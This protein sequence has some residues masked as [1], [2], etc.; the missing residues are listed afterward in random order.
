MAQFGGMPG[1]ALAAGGRVLTRPRAGLSHCAHVCDGDRRLCGAPE[2]QDHGARPAPPAGTLQRGAERG[3][4]V[5]WRFERWSPSSRVSCTPTH[6]RLRAPSGPRPHHRGGVPDPSSLSAGVAKL[7]GPVVSSR[8]KPDHSS[9][10][11]AGHHR[12]G[13]LP[14]GDDSDEGSGTKATTSSDRRQTA[15]P[16]PTPRCRA[17][18]GGPALDLRRPPNAAA[19]APQPRTTELRHPANPS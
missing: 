14:S 3:P 4:A 10:D 11:A 6:R 1:V 2:G 8:T 18:A 5:G 9:C 19:S 17:P 13:L 12:T 15:R 16:G 7:A